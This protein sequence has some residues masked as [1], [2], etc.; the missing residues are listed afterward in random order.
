MYLGNIKQLDESRTLRS[1]I[2]SIIKRSLEYRVR[3]LGRYEFDGRDCA[4]TFS[5]DPLQKETERS[6]EVHEKFLDIQIVLEGSER[7]GFAPFPDRKLITDNRLSTEDI[8]FFDRKMEMG[9][10]DLHEGDFII[11]RQG[12]AH[13]PLCIAKDGG[14]KV[15]KAII[16]LSDTWRRKQNDLEDSAIQENQ[17]LRQAVAE[18]LEKGSGSQ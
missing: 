14:K 7:Y 2:R 16:K 10:A 8:A 4:V 12:E 11:F 9:Y 15:R 6:A 18:A 13:K 3:P 1:C 17:R 5:E